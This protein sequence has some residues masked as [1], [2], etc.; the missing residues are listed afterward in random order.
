MV[1]K[2]ETMKGKW[3]KV[4]DAKCPSDK[5]CLF[6]A[7]WVGYLNSGGEGKANGNRDIS[8]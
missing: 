2:Q 7:A 8:S 6:C 1:I 4:I 3:C 5:D